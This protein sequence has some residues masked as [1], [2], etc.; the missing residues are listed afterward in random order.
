MAAT[1]LDGHTG[2]PSPQPRRLRKAPNLRTVN[3]HT[4]TPQQLRSRLGKVCVAIIAGDVAEM[5]A[6]AETALQEVNFLEFRLDYVPDPLTAI[7]SIEALLHRRPELI[8]IATCRRTPNGGR[9]TGRVAEQLDI[10]LRA[11]AAG[12]RLADIEI[13][14]AEALPSRQL[15]QL[16]R[17]GIA[18]IVSDHDFTGTGDLEAVLR[19]M[20]VFQPDFAKIVSTAKTLTD[21]LAV[22]DLLDRRGGN[23]GIVAIA[24][25]EC[26]APSRVLG[27]RG[28]S[29]FTFGA[30]SAGDES[31]PGQITARDLTALYRIEQVDRETRVFGVAGNHVRSSLSPAMHNAAFRHEHVN[32]VY[33]PLQTT[34]IHD[35][36]RF[37]TELPIDGLSVTMPYKQQILPFLANI[38]SLAARIGAVNTVNRASDGSLHGTNTDEAGIIRPLERRLTLKG[39][40]ALVLGAG[41]AARAA[42]FGLRSQGSEVAISNRSPETATALA[43]QSGATVIPREA[44]PSESF[45]VIVNA[46]PI[47]MTGLLAG[48]P[49][50]PD[51]LRANLVFDLVYNPLETPLLALARQLGIATIS[52][53]EMFVEQGARQFEIWTG[54]E[55]PAEVMLQTVLEALRRER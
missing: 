21:N 18:L 22:F 5:I 15:D 32:A 55:A 50:N 49:L 16:R 4:L 44:L 52:G 53:V 19:R 47:G 9:F 34:D 28:G 12:C 37:V 36:L 25:G 33:L 11:A 13:E 29:A 43:E 3:V 54:R 26:G 51:E 2:P 8:A 14:T 7:P 1:S 31:A 40:R 27:P 6:K 39:A 45:D 48:S 20:E 23:S 35:L 42:V 17:S 41:G 38:D 30:L 46:T 24:M 10:L